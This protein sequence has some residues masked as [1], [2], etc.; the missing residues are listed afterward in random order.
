MG[1]AKKEQPLRDLLRE[2]ELPDKYTKS[3]YQRVMANH[4]L[5]DR[6]LDVRTKAFLDLKAEMMALRMTLEYVY[7]CKIPKNLN[8]THKS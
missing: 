7:L 1:Y 4:K 2:V 3:V 5:K 8:N 6:L